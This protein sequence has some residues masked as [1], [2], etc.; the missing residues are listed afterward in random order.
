MRKIDAHCEMYH[1]HY[2]RCELPLTWQATCEKSHQ[3]DT[4]YDNKYLP[5]EEIY[6]IDGLLTALKEQ[7]LNANIS[8]IDYRRYVRVTLK[9]EADEAEF[10][11]NNLSEKNFTH[12]YYNTYY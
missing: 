8:I 10:I 1:I 9:D 6:F 4:T 5:H 7:N 2:K 3:I 12:I 11:M